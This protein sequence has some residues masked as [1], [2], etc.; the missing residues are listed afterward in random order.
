MTI[1]KYGQPPYRIAVLHGGP[2]APGYMASVAR[3]LSKTAGILEPI[4]SEDSLQGQIEELAEQLKQ[5]TDLPV[6]LI[7]SSWGAVLSLF[8]AS[9]KPELVMKLILIGCAVFD[10]KSSASIEAVRLGR[11]SDENRC[12]Y[13]EIQ[14]KLQ[15]TSEAER[16]KIAEEWGDI[17]FHTD[18]YEPITTDLEVIEV[19]YDLHTKVW[20]DFVVLRDQPGILNAEFSKIKASTVVIHGEYDPHPITGIRPFLESC[21]SDI[22]FHILPKCG[23]YPWIENHAHESFYKIIKS[24]I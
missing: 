3:E 5:C 18:V 20:G 8:L 10:A 23:H 7:G 1:R 12:R 9:Q 15:Q 13:E 6:I 14:T 19:Q 2:G 16:S 17:F 21:L 11:L 24:K 22:K 4:Q